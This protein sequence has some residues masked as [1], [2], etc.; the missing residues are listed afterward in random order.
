MSGKGR[1]VRFHGAYAKKADAERK[2]ARLAGAFIRPIRVRGQRR[3]AV[4]TRASR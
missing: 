3:Y 2:E 1:R 4:M